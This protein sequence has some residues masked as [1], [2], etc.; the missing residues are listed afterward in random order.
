MRRHATKTQVRHVNGHDVASPVLLSREPI[1]IRG[2]ARDEPAAPGAGYH[3]AC[4]Q[5]DADER[6]YAAIPDDLSL[7][8]SAASLPELEDLV[9]EHL[10]KL[11]IRVDRDYIR[12]YRRETTGLQ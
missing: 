1:E 2:H 3:V 7:R 6:W 4:W 10:T 11:G 12:F 9:F 5:E 8:L